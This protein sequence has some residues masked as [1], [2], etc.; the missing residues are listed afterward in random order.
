[1]VNVFKKFHYELSAQAKVCWRPGPA[2]PLVDTVHI[3]TSV[4]VVLSEEVKREIGQVITK[5][6]ARCLTHS[7]LP[8][9]LSLDSLV[10]KSQKTLSRSFEIIMLGDSS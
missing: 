6:I 3:M 5:F 2:S 8:S 4:N 9:I 10:R 1:V 7:E